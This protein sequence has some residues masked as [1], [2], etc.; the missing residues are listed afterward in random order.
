VELEGALDPDH[1]SM[2]ILIPVGPLT[3]AVGVSVR[4]VKAFS[5]DASPVV[6]Q[7]VLLDQN[8]SAVAQ[9]GP[10]WDPG[11]NAAPQSVTI[12]LD[13]APV[14]GNLLVQIAAPSGGTM[15]SSTLQMTTSPSWNL[16][17]VMDVQRQ[18][19]GSAVPTGQT[20]DGVQGAMSLLV[21]TPSGQMVPTPPSLSSESS[22]APGGPP[23]RDASSAYTSAPA[24]GSTNPTSGSSGSFDVRVSTGPLVSRS[25]GPLGPSLAT[26]MTDPAPPV[27]RHERALPQGIDN[28]ASSEEA[29][30]AAGY[31]ELTRFAR[32]RSRPGAGRPA[33]TG[34]AD[35]SVVTVA[36]L[37]AFPLEV[38]TLSGG[39]SRAD[40]GSL[41]ETL[42]GPAAGEDLPAIVAEADRSIPNGSLEILVRLRPST[43]LDQG[44]DYLTAA[45]GLALGLGLTSGVLL[46]DLLA[47]AQSRRPSG[48]L[49]TRLLMRGRHHPTPKARS[50]SIRAW[51]WS[52]VWPD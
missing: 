22:T 5:L 9:V 18:D 34:R 52:R 20:L 32:T 50:R 11:A 13:G 23:G 51:F 30:D 42:P 26:I 33:G 49:L 21:A 37:G 8:G 17:F 48:R 29:T 44:P 16:P 15:S 43:D 36:G 24:S 7:M 40:L 31:L 28:L 46:P 19:A 45:C 2:T 3:Q 47:L 6:E 14:G 39:A 35:D 10:L 12:S 1:T 25:A 41:L 38:A 27:D 4:G